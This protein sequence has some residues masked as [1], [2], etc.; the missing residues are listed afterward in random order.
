MGL[1]PYLGLAGKFSLHFAEPAAGKRQ[2]P[3]AI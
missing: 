1:L 2:Q 3:A